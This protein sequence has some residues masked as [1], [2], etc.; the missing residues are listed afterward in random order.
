MSGGGFIL[1]G[2][3]SGI[4]AGIHDDAVAQREDA[5]QRLREAQQIDAEGRAE[6]RQMRTE[7]RADVREEK[8]DQRDYGQK[9]GLLV[10]GAQIQRAENESREA[11]EMRKT[12]FL[13]SEE[14]QTELLRS[15]LR[16]AETKEEL[17]LRDGLESGKFRG[18]QVGADGQYYGLTDR[19]LT[20]TGV[21][22]APSA[23]EI[24][25]DDTEAATAYED[26]RREWIRGGK[27]GAAPKRSDFSGATR[28]SATGAA[29]APRVDDAAFTAD[30]NRLSRE[31]DIATPETH[32]GL[33]RNGQKIPLAEAQAMIKRSYGVQ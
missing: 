22:A 5:M 9:K 31:Y 11:F 16:R 14:R 19:G 18:V 1:G 28:R 3:L 20:P 21:M 30:I 6:Q 7:D 32:P 26:A 23:A 8:R 25:A 12:A 13:A 2:L 33:F 15:R 10:L 24:K 4:G 17:S 27:A 29:A